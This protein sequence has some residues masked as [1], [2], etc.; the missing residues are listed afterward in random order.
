MTKLL[1]DTPLGLQ[2]VIEVGDGGGYFDPARV[3]WDERKD[4][5]IPVGIQIGGMKRI[6]DA[7]VFDAAKKAAH[8][9]VKSAQEA[10]ELDKATKKAA[11]LLLFKDKNA[12]VKDRLDA[13]IEHLGLDL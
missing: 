11:R 5:L 1:V 12:P 7:L 8:D 10:A 2:E 6:G 4:G 9:V 13:V 3:L